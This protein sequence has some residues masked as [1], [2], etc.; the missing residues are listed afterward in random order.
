MVA[1]DGDVARQLWGRINIHNYRLDV[2][3]APLLRVF[4]AHDAANGRWVMQ[5]MIH[6]L[7]EDMPTMKIVQ[8]EIQVHLDGRGNGSVRPLPF[9]NFVA[10]AKLGVP[11]EE[12]TSFFRKLL[13]DVDEP[14]TPF[15]LSDVRGDGSGI[16]EGYSFVDP[17]LARRLRDRAR[18]F[19]VSA[20]SIFHLA[21]AQVVARVSSRDNDVVFGTLLL[22]RMQGSEGSDR[23]R[24]R[25]S[26]PCPFAFASVIRASRRVFEIHMFY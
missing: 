16:Q 1:A 15:G 19:G 11:C 12:H 24:A 26:T 22:G 25:A 6:H 18:A 3:K 4:I 7:I 2:R 5:Q 13:G 17:A 20:A 9:R 21:W 10:Q 14:T 23:I 8:D